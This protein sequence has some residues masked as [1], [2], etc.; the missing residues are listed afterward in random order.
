MRKESIFSK[1]GN[2][3]TIWTVGPLPVI[4]PKD[5]KSSYHRDVC[6]SMVT[7]ALFTVPKS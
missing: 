7:E 5:T 2:K 4:W 6:T 1:G 3:P